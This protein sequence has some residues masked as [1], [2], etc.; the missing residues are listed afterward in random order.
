VLSDEIAIETR[1]TRKAKRK[2]EQK[3][4]KKDGAGEAAQGAAIAPDQKSAKPKRTP[5]TKKKSQ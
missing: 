2:T 1:E 4:A 3:T 5:K